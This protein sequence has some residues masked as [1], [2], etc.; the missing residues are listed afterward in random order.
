MEPAT[1]TV[2]ED[3]SKEGKTTTH[4]QLEMAPSVSEGEDL[5][6]EEVQLVSKYILLDTNHNNK[7]Y[8]VLQKLFYNY[9][10]ILKI[11]AS[12]YKPLQM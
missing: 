12:M 10:K 5:T 8:M 3:A 2:K 1:P 7:L 11:S 6:P 4:P 9:R